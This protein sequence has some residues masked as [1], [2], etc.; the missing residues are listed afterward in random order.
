M[1][2]EAEVFERDYA[3]RSNVSRAFLQAH[4]QHAHRCDCGDDGC[5]GWKMVHA[6]A[7]DM[8]LS[9]HRLRML[10]GFG[11]LVLAAGLEFDLLMEYVTSDQHVAAANREYWDAL[12]A[13]TWWLHVADASSDSL[14]GRCQRCA[15][16][17]PL[18]EIESVTREVLRDGQLEEEEWLFCVACRNV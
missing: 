17:V 13:A 11:A 3:A 2:T 12:D 18:S 4:G 1:R 10:Q 14:S 8:L 9:P 15:S 6:D 16:E 7:A 5:E